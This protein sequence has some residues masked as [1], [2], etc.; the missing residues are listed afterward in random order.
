VTAHALST[1]FIF[2]FDHRTSAA[3]L[4]LFDRS[5]AVSFCARALPPFNP[6]SLPS[7]TAAAFFFTFAMQN[8]SHDWPGMKA[9]FSWFYD[10]VLTL[11]RRFSAKEDK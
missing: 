5:S 11:V 3:F 10:P 1:A 4:A 6:P 7:F 2:C 8:Y 9:D